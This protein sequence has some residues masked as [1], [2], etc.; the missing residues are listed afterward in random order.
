MQLSNQETVN[1]FVSA[2]KT[3]K[4]KSFPLFIDKKNSSYVG[5]ITITCDALQ[6]SPLN[7]E[8]SKRPSIKIEDLKE[9]SIELGKIP[10]WFKKGK[11]RDSETFLLT[12]DLSVTRKVDLP[13]A[14][15][16]AQDPIE[17]E[18]T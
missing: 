5:F 12:S 6:R 7:I 10:S 2:L 18:T 8:F 15:A 4:L 13:L 11:P 14:Q 17:T 9:V 16:L 3:K 1:V